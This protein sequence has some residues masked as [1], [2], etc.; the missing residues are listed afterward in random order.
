L[1]AG[2]DNTA[3]LL[4]QARQGN[5]AAFEELFA[6]HREQLRG[7]VALR[8]DRRLAA[9]VDVSDVIQETYLEAARRLPDYLDRSD[10][11]FGLWL[12]WLARERVLTLHRQHL[13]AEKR[14][15]GREVQPLPVDSSAQLAAGL[16][17]PGPSPSQAVA[18][19]ELA[20]RLQMALEQL[21]DDERELLVGRHF[22]QLS[23][24]ELAQLLGISEAAANK[25]YIRALQRLR[26]LLKNLGVSGAP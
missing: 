3:E 5:S 4:K 20:E 13:F 2:A 11:P 23:N 18:A 10:I 24:R 21:D 17:G 9:R 7:A 6:R 1:D 15:V 16:L 14:A 12:R 22:E 25:R 8:L 19:I 26:G